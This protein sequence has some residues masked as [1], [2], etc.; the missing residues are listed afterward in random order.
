MLPAY[1][2]QPIGEV[3]REVDQWVRLPLPGG[4]PRRS[5]HCKRTTASTTTTSTR[6]KTKTTKEKAN[7]KE[8]KKGTW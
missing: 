1:S 4:R 3:E 5:S 7:L 2:W 8:R 6:K